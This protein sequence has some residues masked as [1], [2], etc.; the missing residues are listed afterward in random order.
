MQKIMCLAKWTSVN[1]KL[2]FIKRTHCC[3]YAGIRREFSPI[4]L[5][6]E[7]QTRLIFFFFLLIRQKLLWGSFYSCAIFIQYCTFEFSLFL[8]ITKFFKNPWKN[9]KGTLCRYWLRKI[10]KFLEDGI[11][12]FPKDSGTKWKC[13]QWI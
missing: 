11:M 8:V 3:I 12:N 5:L 6:S 10:K 1:Q 2:V 13:V 9:T 4:R 7:N